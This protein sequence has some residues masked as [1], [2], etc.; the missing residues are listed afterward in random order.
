MNSKPQV[1]ISRRYYCAQE[2]LWNAIA[3]GHLFIYTG[4]IKDRLSYEFKKGGKIHIEWN[5]GG[6]ASAMDGEF[7]EVHPQEQIIFTWD[8]S[9][10]IKST[11]FLEVKNLG[12]YCEFNLRHEFPF[13]TATK[14]YDFGWDDAMYDLK[15][16]IYKG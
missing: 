9:D 11:V 16:H 7:L 6:A 4:A 1:N 3:E 13:G 12:E 15:K 5:D 10:G 14:D 2:K 8:T